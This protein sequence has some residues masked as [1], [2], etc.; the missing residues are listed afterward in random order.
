MLGFVPLPNLLKTVRFFYFDSV[1]ET[2]Q[3]E[4]DQIDITLNFI[5]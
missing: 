3:L 5:K 2:Q 1:I 4:L